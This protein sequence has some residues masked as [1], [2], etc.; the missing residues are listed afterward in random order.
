[1]ILCAFLKE[2]WVLSPPQK[3]AVFQRPI[4]RFFG[5][6]NSFQKC[7]TWKCDMISGWMKFWTSCHW[8]DRR[9]PQRFSFLML[10]K[11]D[12]GRW[13]WMPPEWLETTLRISLIWVTRTKYHPRHIVYTL[14]SLFDPHPVLLHSFMEIDNVPMNLIWGTRCWISGIFQ[15]LR[16][17]SDALVQD[18]MIQSNSCVFPQ[19]GVIVADFLKNH[20]SLSNVPEY[21][22]WSIS[23]T[24]PIG[25]GHILWVLYFNNF[26]TDTNPKPLT[27]MF[28]V[29][30]SSK[31]VWGLTVE[32]C[33]AVV[34]GFG[35]WWCWWCWWW[36]VTM[37]LGILSL[38]I[39][40][41]VG[42]LGFGSRQTVFGSICFKACSYI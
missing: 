40:S 8:P 21:I 28:V 7:R 30:S 26:D 12:S 39:L 14:H 36:F 11:C 35:G 13:F 38:Y 9:T 24:G 6:S 31:A 17:C 32:Q 16:R 1:M 10:V 3:K 22:K 42:M 27:M 20:Y 18:W 23:Q 25:H 34:G 37:V 5:R 4:W 29:K 19:A 2:F 33:K 41:K 15:V